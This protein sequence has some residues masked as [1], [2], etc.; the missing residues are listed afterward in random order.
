MSGAGGCLLCGCCWGGCEERAMPWALSRLCPALPL[1]GPALTLLLLAGAGRA[2]GQLPLT[3]EPP[4]LHAPERRGPGPAHGPGEDVPTGPALVP[5]PFRHSALRLPHPEP[6]DAA[7]R[8][9]L[10]PGAECAW[11]GPAGLGSRTHCPQC[12]SSLPGSWQDDSLP[13]AEAALILHRKGFDCSLE[14]KNLGF[15]CTTS[16]GR[17]RAAAASPTTASEPGWAQHGRCQ[18]C[19]PCSRQPRMGLLGAPGSPSSSVPE[20]VTGEESHG[21]ACGPTLPLAQAKLEDVGFSQSGSG[22]FREPHTPREGGQGL[23]WV[24]GVSW[25]SWGL[26]MGCGNSA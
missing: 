14:A 18:S 13:S 10:C 20:L 16:Q 17:V 12:H 26:Q 1:P 6:A 21:A 23:G 15:N 4:H 7:G 2:P 9:E 24:C 22:L 11:P 25:A 5:A 19:P 3:A 8:G